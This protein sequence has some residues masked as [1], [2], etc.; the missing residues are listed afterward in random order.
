[1]LTVQESLNNIA[2]VIS[3]ARMTG[4]EHDALK[5]SVSVV[6]RQ[7]EIADKLEAAVK[8]EQESQKEIEEKVVAETEEVAPLTATQVIEN[9]KKR[10][11]VMDNGPT[12]EPTDV[13]GTNQEDS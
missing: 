2:N 11:E 8:M 4:P 12:N 3:G 6:A 1:M 13:S 5:E 10:L 7:C 9:A